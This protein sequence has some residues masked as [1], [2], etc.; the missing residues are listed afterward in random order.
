MGTTTKTIVITAAISAVLIAFLVWAL[1]GITILEGAA[2]VALSSLVALIIGR[3]REKDVKLT[4]DDE[5]QRHSR[6]RG[7]SG[8]M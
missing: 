3:L 2:V 5:G 7:G 6:G 1:D 4:A 8:L